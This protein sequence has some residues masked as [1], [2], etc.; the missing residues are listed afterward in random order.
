MVKHNNVIPNSHFHKDWQSYIKTWFDQP[1]KKVARR[2]ARKAKAAKAAPRPVGQL[3][4]AVRC[5]TVRYNMR[6][7]AGRGFT[8]AELKAAGISRNDAGTI[9]IAVD[10]RRRNRSQES[11]D[12]NVARLR[13]YLD[14]LVWNPTKPS[15]AIDTTGKDLVGSV[16]AAFPV[17]AA[18]PAATFV[19][20]TDDMR[21]KEAFKATR[22]TYNESKLHGIRL[23][24]ARED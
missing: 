2:A 17:T 14:K 11:L 20:V 4:P 24:R 8:L 19:K 12:A 9:G 15:A 22:Q 21:A 13:A 10:H 1:A 23:R 3:R 6:I 18:A 16:A 7:R 5:P